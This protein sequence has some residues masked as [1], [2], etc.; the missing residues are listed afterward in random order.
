MN[1]AMKSCYLVLAAVICGG[2]NLS[3]DVPR[4]ASLITADRRALPVLYL[5]EKSGQEVIAPGNQPLFVDEETGEIC[6]R[7]FHCTS[8][9]C[10]NQSSQE[11]ERPP[12]FIHRNPT[13]YID[14]QG[15]VSFRE[16]KSSAEFDQLCR[17]YG[18]FLTPTCPAC[19]EVRD[20]ENESPAELQQYI[21]WVQPYVLPESQQMAAALDEE[22]R[23]RLAHMKERRQRVPDDI[24]DGESN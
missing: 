1:D 19:W 18:T 17:Q 13:A 3:E 10:P 23:Q 15:T 24:P 12:L 8:P 11:G 22:H 21:G 2:C 20:P 4:P 14:E 6:Y 5:T 7:A 16:V 9:H